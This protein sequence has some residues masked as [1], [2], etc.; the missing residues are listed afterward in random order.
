MCTISI[1]VILIYTENIHIF[2]VCI[3]YV[4]PEQTGKTSPLN[5]TSLCYLH[6][7]CIVYLSPS[8]PLFTI[9]ARS[10]PDFSYHEAKVRILNI[11]ITWKWSTHSKKRKYFLL[12]KILNQVI[13]GYRH[14][15]VL[16][17]Y[18]WPPFLPTLL[19]I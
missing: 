15:T 16:R 4:I 5:N 7:D 3:T 6:Y 13:T 14:A 2:S 10:L 19:Y 1:F 9:L 12:A 8:F 11:A 17:K 18:L